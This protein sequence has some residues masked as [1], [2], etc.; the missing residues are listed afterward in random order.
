MISFNKPLYIKKYLDKYEWFIE[1]FTIDK[2]RKGII[3]NYNSYSELKNVHYIYIMTSQKKSIEYELNIK[4]NKSNITKNMEKNNQID[5]NI[6][7]ENNKEIIKIEDNNKKTENSNNIEKINIIIEKNNKDKIIENKDKNDK[8]NK[9]NDK[10]SIKKENQNLI[11]NDGTETEQMNNLSNN[12][13]SLEQNQNIN[14]KE[15]KEDLLVKEYQ[16]KK[17]DD[18]NLVKKEEIKIKLENEIEK[19]DDNNINSEII[20]TKNLNR[21]NINNIQIENYS[22]ENNIN[23]IDEKIVINNNINKEIKNTNYVKLNS[24]KCCK[25]CIVF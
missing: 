24:K 23:I 16:C 2:I 7:N 18:S 4:I 3:S 19:C 6:K 13:S 17:L 15:N 5:T 1:I 22:K 10:T 12:I 25:N 21:I 11:K 9:E 8:D 14:K 20:N